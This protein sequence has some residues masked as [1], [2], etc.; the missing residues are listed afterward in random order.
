MRT[1]KK[2]EGLQMINKEVKAEIKDLQIIIDSGKATERKYLKKLLGESAKR[3]TE[4][5]LKEKTEEW[6]TLWPVS[7][8]KIINPSFKKYIEDE[9]LKIRLGEGD[10]KKREIAAGPFR[11]TPE[12][13]RIGVEFFLKNDPERKIKIAGIEGI[14]SRGNVILDLE[15]SGSSK[16]FDVVK[17]ASNKGIELE[18]I[19]NSNLK[20][21]VGENLYETF[22]NLYGKNSI[23]IKYENYFKNFIIEKIIPVGFKNNKRKILDFFNDNLELFDKSNLKENCYIQGDLLGDT[24]IRGN[25]LQEEPTEKFSIFR[26]NEEGSF[27]VIISIKYGKTT[28]KSNIGVWNTSEK[29]TNL[30]AN[31]FNFLVEN[32]IEIPDEKIN[33]VYD[34]EEWNEI[35]NIYG[36]RAQKLK[37]VI[38]NVFGESFNKRR[39]IL[40]KVL[41]KLKKGN[42]G[43]NLNKFFEEFESLSNGSGYLLL[44][45][46][47]DYISIKEMNFLN[48]STFFN[49]LKATLSNSQITFWVNDKKYGA[50]K[51]VNG[52]GSNL[53]L[54]ISGL[55]I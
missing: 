45:K 21:Y 5:Y 31:I 35:Y 46:I 14:N 36:E 20:K 42:T 40:K 33:A 6:Q 17:G 54:D 48:T 11:K 50:L 44:N 37:Y 9:N 51:P 8:E 32:N 23:P 55:N 27:D 3:L 10:F 4:A 2:K 24:I 39:D 41:E 18:D 34:S 1:I 49:N 22:E 28:N 53:R 52:R 7:F 26:K 19:E 13:W 47:G 12:V 16:R 15:I 43:F 25:F 38:D 29:A 30:L